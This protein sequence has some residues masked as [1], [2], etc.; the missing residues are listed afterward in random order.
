MN[1]FRTTIVSIAALAFVGVLTAGAVTYYLNPITLC[2]ATLGTSQC[3]AVHSDGSVQIDTPT[4]ANLYSAITSPPPLGTS[5]G[6]TPSF[7]NGLST[8]VFSIKSSAGWLGK[9]QCD[10]PNT[11]EV[12]LQIFNVASG[13]VTLGTTVPTDI[14]PL[15][16]G[17]NNGW[18]MALP[19]VQYG[20]AMS[21]AVTTT[22]T[23]STAPT[24]TVNCSFA[25]H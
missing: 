25:Y 24:T 8:T 4:S 11:G 13:S 18:V 22:P 5:G 1:W 20:T 7:K 23:G 3:A 16:P 17:L 10:N 15:E 9:A 21:A 14:L 12:F 19:G 2:D 6:W